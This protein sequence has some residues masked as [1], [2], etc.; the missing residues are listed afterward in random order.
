MLQ[1]QLSELFTHHSAHGMGLNDTH[2]MKYAVSD[3]D[4][5]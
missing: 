2:F 5:G 1:S 3:T 4:T